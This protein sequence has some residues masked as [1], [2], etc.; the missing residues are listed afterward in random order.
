ME[1]IP[2]DAEL[3]TNKSI[4]GHDAA[5]YET[6]QYTLRVARD[7]MILLHVK[8][9]EDHIKE[10][11]KSWE[12]LYSAKS[13]DDAWGRYL[14]YMNVLYFLLES[15]MHFPGKRNILL[16]TLFDLNRM[17]LRRVAYGSD[18]VPISQVTYG[19]KQ[20]QDLRRFG[21]VKAKIADKRVVTINKEIVDD[22]ANL[23]E[24]VFSKNV[25]HEVARI[26]SIVCYAKVRNYESS[27]LWA[28]IWLETHIA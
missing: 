3:E 19:D 15:A 18:D 22:L 7:G 6:P 20:R 4:L 21:G 26:A 16:F 24:T 10:V 5:E 1:P 8:E 12:N 11:N 27:L 25:I 28:W 17:N 2:T 14:E 13:F 23:F 9:L